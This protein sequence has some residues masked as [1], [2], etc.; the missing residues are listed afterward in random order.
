ML[1]KNLIYGSSDGVQA[2][3]VSHG[4]GVSGSRRT[5]GVTGQDHTRDT[6]GYEPGSH[7]GHRG[8]RARITQGALHSCRGSP[9][10]LNGHRNDYNVLLTVSLKQWNLCATQLTVAPNS[11][12]SFRACGVREKSSAF[13]STTLLRSHSLTK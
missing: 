5:Q 9:I 3:Q 8:L 4:E 10:L 11:F 1:I 13:I 6:G 7:K 12:H 2:S